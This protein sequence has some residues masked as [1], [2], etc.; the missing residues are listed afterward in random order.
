M[1]SYN[2]LNGVPT[3]GDEQLM[4]GILR[5]QWKWPGFVVSDYDAWANIQR[6]HHYCPTME[7]AAAQGL[8]AGLDQEGGGK[9]AIGALPAALA[10]GNVTKAEINTSFQRLFRIRIKLGMLDPPTMVPWNY[11]K[12]DSSVEGPQHLQA[13]RKVASQGVCMYKNNGV[14]PLD[15]SKLKTV[16]VIGPTTM[17]NDLLLGNYATDPDKGVPSIL[18]AIQSTMGTNVQCTFEP[19]TDYYE[20]GEGGSHASSAKD[21]CQN[22]CGSDPLCKYYTFWENTC[23]KKYNN[24]GKRTSQGRTSGSCTGSR[25]VVSAKGCDSIQCTDTS[26]FD[27]AVKVASTADVV[28]VGLGLDQ[29]I[30]REG[31]DRSTIDL[32][33]GQYALVSALKKAGKPIVG[34]FVHGGTFALKNL[35]TDLDAI[36]DAWYPGQE[37]AYGITDVLFGKENPAGRTPVTWYKDNKDLPAMG[38]MQLYPNASRGSKGIT[39]RYTQ[40]AVDVPFGF[41]LSYTTFSYSALKVQG[42]NFNPCDVINVTVQVQNN[43]T[44]DGDEVVQLYV[45]QPHASVPVPQVRLAAFERVT[46]PRGQTKTVSLSISPIFHSVVEE[47][48]S[49]YDGK[50]KVEAGDFQIFVGRGQP[51]FIPD[52]L[53]ATINVAS[54]A[55][56]F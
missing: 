22:I 50:W 43:G 24:S 4:N 1:C 40:A 37:G 13:A 38:D 32:P 47:T 31:H 35:M 56:C 53:M 2:S 54:T 17:Q 7:C 12:N 51:D 3:C 48:G 25:N 42:S 8:K 20:P 14:L 26:G 6:T 11:L 44:V 28:I 34:V 10:A 33:S 55:T 27:Q 21:C 15:S 52:A 23:Y 30:E 41:G 9:S 18:E 49:V 45:K 46:I 36:L 16:A 5:E 29:S 39:Y 19:N